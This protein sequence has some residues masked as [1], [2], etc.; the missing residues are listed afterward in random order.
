[1]KKPSKKKKSTGGK[2]E[3]VLSPVEEFKE[4]VQPVRDELNLDLV[5]S[6]LWEK[7][8]VLLGKILQAA[9]SLKALSEEKGLAEFAKAASLV[10]QLVSSVIMDEFLYHTGMSIALHI[11]ELLEEEFEYYFFNGQCSDHFAERL[12]ALDDLSGKQEAGAALASAP[13]SAR[14]EE[15]EAVIQEISADTDRSI[16]SDFINEALETLENL[17]AELMEL[18][19]DKESMERINSVF[20]GLHTI[21][22][23]AGFLGLQVLAKLAHEA[24]TVLD[25]YRKGERK[26][27]EEF[28]NCMLS[29]ADSLKNLLL[30]LKQMLGPGAGGDSV[31]PVSINESRMLL[32]FFSSADTGSAPAPVK[33]QAREKKECAVAEKTETHPVQEGKA[34]ATDVVRVPSAKLDDL[35]ELV[36]ELV[37]ALSV[38]SQNEM[39]KGIQDREVREKFNQM[40]K[41]T[42]GLRDKALEIRMF[43]VGSVFAKLTRQVRDLSQKLE[44]KVNLTTAGNET[45]VD[46]Q[47]ID[48]IFSPLMHIVRNAIDHGLEDEEARAKAGKSREGNVTISAFHRGDSVWVEVSDDGKGLDKERILKKAMKTGIINDGAG[49][50]DAQIFDLIFQPGFSTAEKVTDVSG[51]GVGMD[52]VKKMVEKLRGKIVISSEPGKGSSFSLRLPMSTSIIEGLVVRIGKSKFVAPLLSV[53]QTVTPG[54]SE[55][56]SVH[57]RE[58]E[59]FLFQGRLVPVV[60]LY[61]FYGIEPEFKDPSEALIMVVEDGKGAFGLMVDELMHRQQVVIKNI[62]ERFS[63]LRGVSGGTILGNGQIGFILDTEE[64]IRQVRETAEARRREEKG[65]GK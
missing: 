44:K 18:E 17:E 61:D 19:N 58:G 5:I 49:L 56:K 57:D 15:H 13:V 10:H 47:V 43:P 62:R 34:T 23:S 32:D 30:Q 63:T 3:T 14:K 6:D 36:G 52:V 42:E 33:A 39:I 9:D 20:R 1:M 45:L 35:S 64:I 11:H 24:E 16:L 26:V 21:K 22:G 25:K 50:M 12:L 51:R 28:I 59:C 37:V 38:L 29:V 40:E 55:L 2:N 7:D 41:I 54:K 8:T 60:R 65:E 48:E 4:R 27:T 31:S 46:K 53:R